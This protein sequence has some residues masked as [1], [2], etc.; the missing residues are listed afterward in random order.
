MLV[1]ELHEQRPKVSERDGSVGKVHR[2][3]R[4]HAGHRLAE[5]LADHDLVA[6]RNLDDDRPKVLGLH[7]FLNDRGNGRRLIRL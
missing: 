3:G 5:R 6:L 2:S 1:H 4:R 7:R